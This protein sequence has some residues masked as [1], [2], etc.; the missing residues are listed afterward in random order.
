MKISFIV[1]T[2]NRDKKLEECLKSIDQSVMVCSGVTI[3]IIVIYQNGNSPTHELI[4]NH[5]NTQFLTIETKGLALSRNYAISKSTGD[6]LVFIDDDAAIDPGFIK[7]LKS[8]IE[9]THTNA[10]CGKII[11]SS[12]NENFT[13]HFSLNRN[14]QLR[15]SDYRLFMGSSH[16]LSKNLLT[17]LG[18]Y[19]EMFG[20]GAQ[21]PAAEETDLFFRILRNKE[22]VLYIP[23]LVFMHSIEN[24]TR[25]EKVFKYSFAIGAMFAKQ[26]FNDPWHCIYY[27]YMVAN[28]LLRSAVRMVQYIIVPHSIELK[29]NRFH[30]RAVFE[31]T[32]HGFLSYCKK[33]T[34]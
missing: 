22:K 26:I 33:G 1:A 7:V 21:Y 9:S 31:G 17:R 18:G 20:A 30:Y 4:A 27:I 6:Y 28:I 3:D 13:G 19:D 25:K 24:V 11:D 23:E 2:M 5:P 34:H 29:N 8:V 12:S 16:I 32:I 10:Y 15:M 14:M